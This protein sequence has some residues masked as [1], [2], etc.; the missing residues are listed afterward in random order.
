MIRNITGLLKRK[1]VLIK[2]GSTIR[3]IIC[4]KC[5]TGVPYIHM[6]VEEFQWSVGGP[7]GQAAAVIGQHAVRC[8][9]KDEHRVC[10]LA[11]SPAR[12]PA[13]YPPSSCA[14]RA[15][16]RCS[17]HG[18]PFLRSPLQTMLS[19]FSTALHHSSTAEPKA[20]EWFYHLQVCP[21]HHCAHFIWKIHAIF[22]VKCYSCIAW[23]RF[24]C[25]SN[26]S[27]M[28][29]QRCFLIPSLTAHSSSVLHMG[30]WNR[31]RG[32]EEGWMQIYF[33]YF[34]SQMKTDLAI[35]CRF[36]CGNALQQAHIGL[37]LIY[38]V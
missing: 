31:P 29:M 26:S 2:P 15:A 30:N 37:S 38:T 27:L 6:A 12:H 8:C 4:Q 25:A 9:R 21:S 23:N 18:H 22:S 28:N 10:W 11:G 13:L 34:G 17:R 24:R 36:A 16:R 33:G 35:R 1:H 3:H 32:S 19:I 7:I 20:L 14:L 5:L